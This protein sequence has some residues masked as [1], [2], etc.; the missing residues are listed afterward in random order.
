MLSLIL[1]FTS[2]LVISFFPKKSVKWFCKGCELIYKFVVELV[3]EAE[4][5]TE[6]LFFLRGQGFV[7]GL[8]LK[9]M[10]ASFIHL[11]T[12]TFNRFCQNSNFFNNFTNITYYIYTN[13]LFTHTFILF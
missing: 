13:I 6:V 1:L 5:A 12:R 7:D 4:E 10:E 11:E 2:Q 9:G 3:D 8:A